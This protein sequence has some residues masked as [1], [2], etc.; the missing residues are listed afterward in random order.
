MITKIDY[1]QKLINFCIVK[2]MFKVRETPIV[3]SELPAKFWIKT[4]EYGDQEIVKWSRP[5]YIM[6]MWNDDVNMKKEEGLDI[7]NSYGY[8]IKSWNV[9]SEFTYGRY[10][11]GGNKHL[12]QILIQE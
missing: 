3:P 10:A 5:I 6:I 7:N 2:T 4:G 8:A 1:I 11:E 9:D 12:M